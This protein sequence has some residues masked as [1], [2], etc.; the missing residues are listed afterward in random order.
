M[1]EARTFGSAWDRWSGVGPYYAMFPVSFADG[2]IAQH[3]IKGDAVLDPFAGRGTAPFSAA[4]LGRVGIGIEVNPVGW[5]YGAA[6]LHPAAEGDVLARLRQVARD[7]GRFRLAARAMPEFFQECFDPGVLSFLLSARS[8]LDWRRRSVDRTLAA[9][10][11]IYLHGKRDFALSNQMR[12]TK[13]MAPNYSIAWWRER[14]LKPR[15]LDPVEFLEARIRWRYAKGIPDH[16]SSVMRL[17]DSREHLKRMSRRRKGSVALLLTSPPYFGI[18]NYFYDQWLRLWLLGGEPTD[19]RVGGAVKGKFE[20]L[21]TYR[22]L[23][24]SVFTLS[25]PLLKE[26]ATIYVRTD[27]RP[28]TLSTTSEVLGSVFPEWTQRPHARPLDKDSQTSLF[29]GSCRRE[30]EVD[31]VL[32]RR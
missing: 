30:G 22:A 10:L 28:K 19:A 21:S 14:G 6:K 31:L 7:T 2:V 16:T 18:T 11:L 1:T 12:Q 3:T 15:A 32:T 5:L 4:A 26:D 20:D 8:S 29:G 24:L 9:L 17:G 13:A 23:L 25:R 27:S